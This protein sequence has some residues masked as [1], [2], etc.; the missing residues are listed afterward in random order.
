MAVVEI[1]TT[2]T[3]SSVSATNIVSC[4]ICQAEKTDTKDRRRKEK[5][6]SCQTFAAC[7]SL[8]KAAQVRGDQRV[9]VALNGQDP[10]ALDVCYHRS[11][12]RQYIKVKET[13]LN[14]DCDKNCEMQIYDEAFQ[15]LKVDMKEKLLKKI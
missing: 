1:G 10:I 11:C 2:L 12:Y 8:A 6:T 15:E 5:L 9:I 4:I 3:R 13:E 7:E 14:D